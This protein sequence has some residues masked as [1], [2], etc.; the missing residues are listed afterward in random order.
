MTE[1]QER[2]NQFG[3][4]VEPSKTALIRFGSQAAKECGKD[5]AKRPA[6]FNFLGFTH[7]VGKSR[8]GRFIVGRTIQHDRITKK[9]KEVNQKLAKLRLQGGKAMMLHARRHLVGHVT[10][11]GVSGNARQISTY[12]YLISR[13]LFKWINRRSQRR[14]CNWAKFSKVLRAWMP[15][16]RIQ[17]N[18]YPKPLWMT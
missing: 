7:Y 13:L 11:Y 15:S 18:L 2:L 3:L 12:A 5:G 4:E 1:M 10:Y 9:L 6:T 8:K 17:H 16:L 14:S